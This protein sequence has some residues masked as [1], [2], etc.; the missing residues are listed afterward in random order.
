M[1]TEMK[2]KL[3]AAGEHSDYSSL[4]LVQWAKID[5]VPSTR[6]QISNVS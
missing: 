1:D 5:T 6:S 2:K 4:S 3:G